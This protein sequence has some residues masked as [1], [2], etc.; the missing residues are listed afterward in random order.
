VI[1]NSTV[2]NNSSG[3]GAGTGGGGIYN[4]DGT[5][6]ITNSTISG[7]KTNDG[8]GRG[9]GIDN[10]TTLNLS[11]VTVTNNSAQLEGGGIFN[12][13]TVT[14]KN[15]VIAQNSGPSDSPDCFGTLISHGYNLLGKVCPL[16]LSVCQLPGRAD[17]Q[18][19][20]KAGDRIGTVL[21]PIDPLLGP[22]QD[23]GGFTM[24]QALLRGSPAIDAGNPA[25]PGTE[26]NACE[27]ADQRGVVRPQ[28]GNNDGFKRCDIG[29]FEL[30]ATPP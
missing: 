19:I 28:D 20:P 17:C 24:T 1:E 5:L 27:V 6:S 11:N 14:L 3:A 22:L 13:G 16:A 26:P 21:D 8:N 10:A 4:L 12:A 18:I 29:A 30:R 7:N 25:R 2:S 23:N 9:G 15:T